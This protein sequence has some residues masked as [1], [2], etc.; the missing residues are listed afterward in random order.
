[1][2]EVEIKR[3]CPQCQGDGLFGAVNGPHGSGDKP[4]D[5]NG[6]NQT[7]YISFGKFILDPSM[8]DLQDK[9][10]DILDKIED[11]KE[12]IQEL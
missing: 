7:G 11:I 6:C 8:D 1:M 12:L 4:C 3:V 10:Q 5:W 2:A 9:H